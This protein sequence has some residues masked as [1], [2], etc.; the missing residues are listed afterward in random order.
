M[1]AVMEKSLTEHVQDAG[2]EMLFL[3]GGFLALSVTPTWAAD[4]E[5]A[6]PAEVDSSAVTV[7]TVQ[8]G[9]GG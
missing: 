3:L 4:A 6:A 5:E 9:G 8:I 2:Y 7:T 1:L